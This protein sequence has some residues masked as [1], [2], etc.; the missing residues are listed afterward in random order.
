MIDKTIRVT[1]P[2]SKDLH[3]SGDTSQLDIAKTVRKEPIGTP[4]VTTTVT[5][6]VKP[7]TTT[8]VPRIPKATGV[9]KTIR[10]T[11]PNA[12]T[13]KPQNLS[14]TLPSAPKEQ[15]S[16]STTSV[17]LDRESMQKPSDDK[18]VA[19]DSFVLKGVVY[20]N[21]KCLSD[22]SGEAQVF[23]VSNDDGRFVLKVYYANF[24]V[25]KQVLKIIQNIEL[26]FIT[27]VY[28][29]GKT[30]VDGVNRD[31]ELMEYLE[32]ESL[33]EFR[34]N[35]DIHRFRH[36][37]LQAAASLSMLHNEG[38][39]HK[40][41]KPG[42][43]FFRDKAQTQ[44]VLGDFGIST[45]FTESELLHRTTQAR[46]PLYAAPEM[47]SDVID[48]EVEVTPAVDFYSLGLTL[49]IVWLGEN[50]LNTNERNIMRRKTEG[51]LP[52]MEDLPQNVRMIIQGL[53]AVNP[54]NRW[55]YNEV[56][57]WF[58][59]ENVEVDISSP[60]LNYKSFVVD[61][62]RNLVAENVHEL[63]PL[64]IENEKVAIGYLYG[65]RITQWLDNCG[66][67]KL[68][69]SV[70]DIITN[71]YPV[72]QQA[73]FMACV[74]AMEPTYPYIDI[75]GNA[76]K[77]IRHLVMSLLNNQEEYGLV[78]RNP[79]NRL[80]LYVEAHVRCNITR[81][82]AY[83]EHPEKQ[84][85]RKSI[86]CL[87]YE[88]DKS[89]PFLAQESSDTLQDIVK[90]FGTKKM[91]DDAWDSLYD[92]RLLAW[93]YSH[94]DMVA[95][96]SLRILTENKEP[97]RQLSYKV[98]YHVDRNA[99][100]D[101]KHADTPQ[102]IGEILRDELKSIEYLK[103]DEYAARILDFSDTDGRFVYYA[104]LHGWH[105]MME[106]CRKC[107]DLTSTENRE[108]LSAYDLKTAAYRFC[109]IL[110]VS[111]AYVMQDGTILD[112]G[113]NI[114]QFR[115]SEFRT[116]MRIGSF[117]QWLSVWYHEDPTNAFAEEYSYEHTLEA[118]VKVL[119]EFDQQQTY[120]KRF[121]S[122]QE[123]TARRMQNVKQNY[124]VARGKELMWK[125]GFY[126]LCGLWILLLLVCGVSGRD[127]LFNHP[128]V[129]MGIPL[130][131]MS[132]LIVASRSF[133]RGYGFLFSL[134]WGGLGLL[135]SV[136]P[137]WILKKVQSIQPDM[138]VPAIILLT[139]V[140]ALICYFTDYSRSRKGDNKLIKQVMDNDIKSELLEPLYYT[141]KQKS[142]RYKGSK[143]GLF[144]DV[145]N[146]IHSVAGESVVHYV[147]W[148]TLIGLFLI[149][150]IVFNPRLM[151][152]KNPNLNK[153][154]SVKEEMIQKL[155]R[156]LK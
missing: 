69:M 79:N 96:E 118:W 54:Q 6:T 21:E 9:V 67:V 68:G 39:I 58:L 132:A 147:L 48:G 56:E 51:R 40:D 123:E 24:S 62:E 35:G 122:A 20:H 104:Q 93:M 46:T 15:V 144:E 2:N 3:T 30:Y 34:L 64:L 82:R 55:G 25:Q 109:R 141:F 53:T 57:R 140:Y 87:V 37:A 38:I 47:Y 124:Q 76:C 32:G 95:C 43:F 102:K 27:H 92:G 151:N 77:D 149:E 18:V 44:I 142:Y 17:P 45:Y 86:L 33:E 136:V 42:N 5:T 19:M 108:R 36:I 156:E 12:N 65:G 94:E 100:Y 49:L 152:V 66:N 22:S 71:R 130:G 105:D 146:Q 50:P 129:T 107:F 8:T 74:Y 10:I 73:G 78:L 145:Q 139:L 128:L 52:R 97:S 60:I 110:G 116:E 133:F 111:P 148:C 23:L 155:N 127:Y 135:S 81:L 114:K 106:A 138:F 112:N 153:G 113:L 4:G 70:R 13:E 63:I 59:G 88:L 91:S 72:D 115:R 90:A 89:V 99:A 28:D 134:M 11:I 137:V 121:K 7:G 85:P 98:L 143:F 101:L 29:F 120:Y 125:W 150:M 61:P 154:V 41:I 1:V 16:A 83:F 84:D 26:E 117:T 103:D 126:L 31:Y 14:T 131:G 80:W 75:K 119:G